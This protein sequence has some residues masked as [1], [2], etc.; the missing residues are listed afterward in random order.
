M[1]ARCCQDNPIRRAAGRAPSERQRVL[2]TRNCEP[3]ASRR[4]SKAASRST[5]CR[6]W[7]APRS[8]AGSCPA[9]RRGREGDARAVL[10]DDQ[11]V[12]TQLDLPTLSAPSA[13]SEEIIGPI[14]KLSAEFWP[15][16]V[17]L[18]T[19]S[20][21]ATDGS[22]LRNAGIPTYGHSGLAGDIAENRAPWPRRAHSR[23]ILLRRRRVFV[24][25]REGIRRRTMKGPS[26]RLRPSDSGDACRKLRDTDCR[27]RRG[28][29]RSRSTPSASSF[30][31]RRSHGRSG[32]DD[33]RGPSDRHDRG[34]G[35]RACRVRHGRGHVQ[36]P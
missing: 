3:H 8:I 15:G 28:A 26:R 23:Q 31:R 22:Y 14:T 16:A 5:R 35:H 9:S 36:P 29:V 18:P 30:R 34:H 19:M 1:C 7:R 13:L 21:G 17:V 33:D 6:N 10:A 4:C 2:S 11:I 24:P 25:S 12:V 27:H 32:D 20:T